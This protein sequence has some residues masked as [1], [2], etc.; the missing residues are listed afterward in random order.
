MKSRHR[1]AN[2]SLRRVTIVA[3]FAL[4]AAACHLV[5]PE[6]NTASADA[7]PAP[8]EDRLQAAF[9]ELERSGVTAL[10]AVSHQG[11]P[12]VIREFGAAKNDTVPGGRTQVD[13]NSIT[14][15]VTGVAFLKLA[16]QGK[17]KFDERL[18]EIFP[19]VP[20]D[21]ADITVHHLLTHSAG[22]VDSVGPDP[23]R[24]SKEEFLLRTFASRLLSAPG[25]K[26]R[27]SNV[28]FSVLAAI[29]ELRSGKSYEAYLREDVLRGLGLEDT[30]YMAVYDEARSLRTE[31]GLPILQASW[32]G[33]EPYWNLIG[34][35]GLVSTAEDFIKFRQ[36]LT[37]G[38]IVPLDLVKLSQT[39]LV[40]ESK[41][42][43]SHYG[44]GLVVQHKP[45]LGRFYW[46][47]GGNGVFTAKWIDY[48]DQGDLIF[49][50]AADSS[51]GDAFEVLSIVEKHLYGATSE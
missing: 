33:H 29:L 49:T 48:L 11:G 51:R 25:K 31:K 38:R 9:A 27:Y 4:L 21:K 19:N 17:V 20:Q 10:V 40:A 8:F 30:G 26:Y 7:K 3:S 50:A 6:G 14:K 15:T 13:I 2:L 16:A 34:N 42:G 41:F 23:E 12:V 22:L 47:D 24:L 18:G 1:Y 28:G 39:E 43:D 35:G 44:Y 46:H 32:G 45:K 37:A 5:T 36:A